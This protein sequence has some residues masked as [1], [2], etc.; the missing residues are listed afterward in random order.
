MNTLA[1][2]DAGETGV[3]GQCLGR[4]LAHGVVVY[5]KGELGAGKTT[6]VRGVLQGRGYRGPVR[7][8]TYTLVEGYELDGRMLYHLD[9]YRIRGIVELEYLGIRDLD[10]PD[11]WVFIEWPERGAGGLPT[12]DLTLRFDMCEPGRNINIEPANAR[13]QELAS[14]WGAALRANHARAEAHFGHQL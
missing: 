4:A 14:A 11:L 1:A 10:D 6:F 7:S 5:L 13:G 9:L 12:A 8:P 3:L 2:K